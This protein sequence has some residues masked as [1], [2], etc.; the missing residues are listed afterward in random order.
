MIQGW[1]RHT[2]VHAFEDAPRVC[3]LSVH[4]STFRIPQDQ[5]KH[6]GVPLSVLAE[7]QSDGMLVEATTFVCERIIKGSRAWEAQVQD[8]SYQLQC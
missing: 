7:G 5:V 4:L 2:A 1:R 6:G 3:C 8:P